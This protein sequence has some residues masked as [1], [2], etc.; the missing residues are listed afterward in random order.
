MS[1]DSSGACRLA[2]RSEDGEPLPLLLQ[3]RVSASVDVDTYRGLIWV[4]FGL[5][6][7]L[8]LIQAAASPSGWLWTAIRVLIFLMWLIGIT[9]W[10]AAAVRERRHRRRSS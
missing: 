7:L 6:G 8:G 4:G 1:L 10:L 3:S 9:G 2:R 5:G